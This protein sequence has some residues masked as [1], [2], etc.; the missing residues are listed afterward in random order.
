MFID[1]LTTNAR[2]LLVLLALPMLAPAEQASRFLSVN[3]G[4]YHTCAL[5]ADG[6][7]VCWGSNKNGQLGRGT[8]GAGQSIPR[9]V[10]GSPKYI[11]LAAGANH[12]C[13]LTA[14]GVVQCWGYNAFGQLGVKTPD[15]SPTPVIV[16]TQT[17]VRFVEIAAGFTHTCAIAQGGAAWCWG[18][19]RAGQVGDGGSG[20]WSW[21]PSRV[22]APDGTRFS[23]IGTGNSFTCGLADSQAVYCWGMGTYNSLGTP[24]NERC[25]TGRNQ[26]APCA[27]KPLAVGTVR[28][29]ALAVGSSHAC[30]I[31]IDGRTLCWG[32][33]FGGTPKPIDGGHSFAMLAAGS[34]HDCGLENGTVLCWGW[35]TSGQ[36]GD[37]STDS[38]TLPVAVKTTS[39]FGSVRAGASHACAIT[40]DQSLV[41]WG[42]N[43]DGQL[44]NGSITPSSTP[45]HVQ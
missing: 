31:A 5:A 43:Q 27:T 17:P 1:V 10:S 8:T 2:A 41:C 34:N 19:E 40:A 30:V 20:G 36:L 12:T 14:N 28:A 32:G 7:A 29:R 4:W 35:N 15:V 18:D 33:S 16:Q 11:R 44:G 24:A 39:T 38:S 37:G 25:A 45:V 3:P 23:A 26:S 42:D 22:R 13:G 6:T 9:P 21:V